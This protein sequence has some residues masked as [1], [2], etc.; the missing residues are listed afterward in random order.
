[1]GGGNIYNFSMAGYAVL[2]CIPP[3]GSARL[4]HRNHRIVTLDNARLRPFAFVLFGPARHFGALNQVDGGFRIGGAIRLA[5]ATKPE[6]C[7]YLGDINFRTNIFKFIDP[8][9]LVMVFDE[10]ITLGFRVTAYS[11]VWLPFI[12]LCPR[13]AGLF[14]CYICDFLPLCKQ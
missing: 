14:V 2:L 10:Q 12:A 13:V 11:G 3:A 4:L 1:M 8:A 6:P 7:V 5:H 9:R